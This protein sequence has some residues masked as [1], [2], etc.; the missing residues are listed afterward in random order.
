MIH[1]YTWSTPN[2]RKVSILLEELGLAYEVHAVNLSQ[3]EQ[4]SPAFL[5]ISPNNRIPAL[6]DE[7]ADGSPLSVF[8]SGA[9]LTYL[10]ERHGRFLDADGS[11]RFKALEWLHWQMGGL[12]PMVG[13]VAYFEKL[14]KEKSDVASRRF[15]LESDRLFGVM[16]KRLTLVPFL[17]GDDYS[18]ADMACYPW[19][20]TAQTFLQDTLAEK[21]ADKPALLAWAE[22]LSQRPAVQRGMA[23]P[24]ID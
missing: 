20:V 17:A 12:G 22:R 9:I 14:A 8:E 5:A 15:I 1:L 7:Q 11:G 3:Q 2:G 16:E 21:L 19:I 10:A 13:Q 24:K 6:V 4:F 18:I 23:V